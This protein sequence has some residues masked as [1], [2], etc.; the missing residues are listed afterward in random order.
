MFF[1]GKDEPQKCYGDRISANSLQRISVYRRSHQ[2][3]VDG[4]E[5]SCPFAVDYDD[6]KGPAGR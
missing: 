3:D 4:T 2:D 5:F 1:L 6:M